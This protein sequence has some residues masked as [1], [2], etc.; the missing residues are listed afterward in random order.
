MA[1]RE[2]PVSLRRLIVEV[3]VGGLNVTRF[4][5]Q[6]GVSTWFFYDL[7]RRYTAGGVDAIEARSRA[8]HRVANRIPVELEGQ[9]VALRKELTDAG[10]DA[11]PA[12]IAYH[13]KARAVPGVPSESGIWRVLSRR[14]FIV[15]DPS[16]APKRARRRFAAE[17]ANECW[18]ADDT[19]WELADGT[20]VK[21][22]DVVDDCTRV[23]AAARVT[24][25]ATAAAIFDAL[26]HG[27]QRWG[28]P[29]RVLWDNARA[30]HALSDTLGALGIAT[31][32]SRPYH[33]QTCGKVERF[34]QTVKRYLAAQPQAGTVA[35][36]QDQLDRFLDVYNYQRPHRALGRHLPTAVWEA[37]PKSGPANRPLDT[38]TT[39]HRA[40]VDPKGLLSAGAY[41]ISVGN[42]H[43]GRSATTVITGHAAHV[44][45]DGHLVRQ[46]T[47]DPT[48]EHQ[49]LHPRP[50]RPRRLP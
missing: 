8:P 43:R 19:G 27:A 35:E 25:T 39:V 14:G 15:P 2:I 20:T 24:P 7:R 40:T 17:R 32:H 45:I 36:L 23:A 30:H 16:K 4:C 3:D 6:H 21:I 13:L 34:H 12:T 31:G 1:G 46:L 42:A 28:W 44:F 9:I 38:P 11:G 37:T 33:P 49:T 26:T 18:Q 47:I 5:E 29:E 50:G 48:R 22:I 41:R 10:L